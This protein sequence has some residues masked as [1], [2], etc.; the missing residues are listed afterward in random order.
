M[1][2][3][4]GEGSISA[5]VIADS[6]ANG[7]RLTTLE[8]YYPRFIHAEFL[9]HRQFSRNASSSRAIP[10]KRM[11]EQVENNPAMPIHWGKN[12][13]GMQ[14]REECN[15]ALDLRDWDDLRDEPTREEAWRE[16]AHAAHRVSLEFSRV[17]Y[18]KQIANRLTEPFQFIKVVVTA[19]EYDNFFALRLHEASQPEIHELARV[20]KGAMCQSEPEER[21]VGEHHLP[22][23]KDGE[24]H[25]YDWNP[26]T[27]T[28]AIKCSV[29]RCAR[30]SYNNHDGSNCDVESDI[31]LYD[32]LLE[33]GH[34]SPFEHVASPMRM[35]QEDGRTKW[36]NGTTH[37]D[38]DGSL[39][40]GNFRGF[41]QH[42]QTLGNKNGY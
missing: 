33:A 17:G 16:A 35:T 13:P 29:A 7:V 10:V 34:M 36:D 14:A 28:D 6:I 20:M 37:C 25:K 8:L 21:S 9:T 40:S 26:F 11:L 12:Q 38:G 31:R 2:K 30:V 41:I 27:S 42:R 24:W 1:K 19:A 32:Q 15:E 39:W 3:V 5:T 18:H 23:I 22:Y 4:E